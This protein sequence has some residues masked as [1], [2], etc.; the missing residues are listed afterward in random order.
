MLRFSFQF[1]VVASTAV[2]CLAAVAQAPLINPGAIDAI[3][4]T[5]LEGGEIIA[6]IDGDTVLA[7]DLA[8]QIEH[9]IETAKSEIP[10]DQVD[11]FRQVMMRRQVLQLI[12][13]KILYADFRRTVPSE[14]LPKVEQSL[15]EAF[16]EIEIPRLYAMMKLETRPQL[17]TK[18]AESGS[19]LKDVQRQF[20]EKTI[21]T[22]WLKQKLP[23]AKV[24]THDQMLAYYQEHAADYEYPAQVEWEEL[25]VRFDRCGN[26]RVKAWQMLCEMGNE[27]WMKAQQNPGIR[28]PIFSDVA[29]AKSH[30]FTARDGGVYQRETLGARTCEA[31]NDALAT[32]QVGQMSDG[33]ESDQGFHI[34]RVLS[35]RDAGKTPFTT[36]QKQIRKIIEAQQREADIERT[37]ADLRKNAKAWTIFDGDLTGAEVT[38]LLDEMQR[39]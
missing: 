10:R 7:A 20:N 15:S 34:V 37:L 17:E 3:E 8:W 23:K 4:P 27:A 18:L 24:V 31:L 6:R 13:T 38:A 12:D 1:V 26:D 32:L 33:F 29:K 9:I 39:R 14:N 11:Q 5:P 2:A 35:R 19:S 21:A 22:E 28:G 25:M 36:A 30:G 16:E